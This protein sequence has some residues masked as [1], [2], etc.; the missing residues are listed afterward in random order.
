MAYAL[1]GAAHPY[2]F[3]FSDRR[4][5]ALL[6][7]A[8]RHGW[9]P[10]GTVIYQNHVAQRFKFS[11]PEAYL[12]RR[13]QI[14]M[15]RDA[16]NLAQ[17]LEQGLDDIPDFVTPNKY[18]PLSELWHDVYGILSGTEEKDYLREFI[19]FCR[20]CEFIIA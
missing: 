12:E 15:A 13:E 6:L 17:A 10:T 5:Y 14:V 16:A 20:A 19:R 4:W 11:F 3:R 7:L 2:T 18:R 9:R 8:R 1:R